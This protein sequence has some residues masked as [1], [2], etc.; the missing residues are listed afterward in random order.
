PVGGTPGSPDRAYSSRLGL[1]VRDLCARHGLIDR[2]PRYIGPGAL[3]TNKRIAEMLFLRTYDLELEQADAYRI[4]AY[5]KAAWAVDELEVDVAGIYH[6]QGETGLQETPG[7][8]RSISR[9]ISRW[10]REHPVE[11]PGGTGDR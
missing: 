2:M 3:A 8:G 7:I 11:Q 1:T 4:W 9:E 5:R 10:L 6:A